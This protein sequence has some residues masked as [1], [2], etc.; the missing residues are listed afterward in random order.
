MFISTEQLQSGLAGRYGITRELGAGGMATV[1]LAQD[2]KHERPVALKVLRPDLA[3]ILGSERFLKEIRL[4][5]NLHHPHILPLL[6]SGRIDVPVDAEVHRGAEAPTA[7][8]PDRPTALLYY[9]M[10]FVEGESLRDR[11]TREQQLPVE[12][13]IRIATEVADALQYAHGQGVIHRDIKPENILL[14]GGHALVADFGIALAASR[15][16]GAARITETGLSLG[17]PAYMA[18]EQ[19]MGVRDLTPKA[20]IYALGCVLYEMLA[21]EPPFTGPTAQAIAARVMTED[22]RPLSLERRTIPLQVEAAVGKALEKLPADRFASAAEFAAALAGP[23]PA[24]REETSGRGSR[25]RTAELARRSGIRSR[26]AIAVLALVAA[27]ALF[28]LALVL[29]RRGDQGAAGGPVRFTVTLPP[30]DRLFDGE[31]T[32]LL[33]PD[34]SR[35]LMEVTHAGRRQ[36]FLRELGRLEVTAIPGTDGALGPCF[37]PDGDWIAFSANGKLVKVPVTG[38]TPTTLADAEWGGGTW[39]EDGRIIYTPSYQGGLWRV[40]A[41]G[42]KA[43][44]LTAPDTASGELGHWWPQLLPDGRHVLFTDYVTPAVKSRIEVL[45]LATGR[46]QVLVPAGVMGRYASGRL[47]YARDGTLFSLPFD[48]RHLR[49][50]GPALP[51]VQNVGGNLSSGMTAYSVTGSAMAYVPADPAN[52]YTRP[53]W[54]TRSGVAAPV[55]LQPG[56]YTNPAI[57]ADGRRIAFSVASGPARRDIWV[58]H[59]GRDILTRATFEQNSGFGPLWTADGQGLFYNSEQPAFDIYVHAAEGDAPAQPVVTSRDDKFVQSVSPDGQRLAFI[60]NHSSSQEIDIAS[61]AGPPDVRTYLTGRPHLGHPDFSPN[62]KWLVYDSDESGRFEVYLQSFP[63]PGRMRVQLSAG[64]GAEPLW[65][66]EGREVV[67]RNGDSLM[68]L[69]VDPATGTAGHPTFLFAGSY[70]PVWFPRSYDVTP[71]G[72]RF[73][74]IVESPLSALREVEVV[75]GWRGEKREKA[76]RTE[77]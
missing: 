66:R 4:T 70:P 56:F 5:A 17:T 51:V 22:P 76:K 54:V 3:A 69:E 19:A 74:M 40:S 33:S 55:P 2:L 42:G 39:G 38:G 65:T 8:P 52:S 24:A 57:A 36:L 59:A 68:A 61:L 21:G 27:G 63:D 47:M 20:D 60:V 75:V 9:V 26:V 67:Y 32:V 71:D 25:A 12:D 13:A 6:D 49:A 34:G 45:D 16:E 30:G 73:L 14:Y 37:S 53:L 72:Q 58:Y 10:P 64:G 11:L 50:T 77:N 35:L 46:R 28:A 43:E 48:V 15:S 23:A 31:P 29:L 7:F 44:M 41:E 18:P 1:Y 62:G